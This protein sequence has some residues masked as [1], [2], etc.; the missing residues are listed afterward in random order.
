MTSSTMRKMKA[1]KKKIAER[2]NV[3]PEEN[4]I[5]I[6]KKDREKDSEN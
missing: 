4:E 2:H 1:L 3:K 5:P 6:E